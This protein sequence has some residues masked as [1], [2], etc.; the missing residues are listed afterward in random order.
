[1]NCTTTTK[2]NK[3]GRSD[4]PK[5]EQ[6]HTHA[7]VKV[8]FENKKFT[9][10][11]VLWKNKKCLY[12]IRREKPTAATPRLAMNPEGRERN[13]FSHPFHPCR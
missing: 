10:Q 13:F 12:T 4:S 2:R 3:Q 9:L 11:F 1:M 5:Q 8:S 6:A 7:H